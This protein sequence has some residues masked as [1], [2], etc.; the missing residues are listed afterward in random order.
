MT[1]KLHPL[2]AEHF[3][4]VH[5]NTAQE[6][7]AE[8]RIEHSIDMGSFTVNHG[9]RFGAPI[10]IVEHNTHGANDLDA[11]WYDEGVPY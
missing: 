1:Q 5:K 9:T 6:T 2:L 11:I 4:A 10:M 7:K 3:Y 8:S